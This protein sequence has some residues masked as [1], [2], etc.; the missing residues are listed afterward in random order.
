M[1]EVVY[2]G[3]VKLV[4]I[5]PSSGVHVLDF[6]MPHFLR[7]FRQVQPIATSSL[8]TDN[9]FSVWLVRIKKGC[10]TFELL[11][12]LEFIFTRMSCAKNFKRFVDRHIFMHALTTYDYAGRT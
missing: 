12:A 8:H 9:G 4:L 3:L 7:F 2:D 6:L 5:D 11:W 1:K 10:Y